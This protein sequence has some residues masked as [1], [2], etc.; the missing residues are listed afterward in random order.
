MVQQ[1]Y[2][3]NGSGAIAFY[4]ITF[5]RDAFCRSETYANHPGLI[6]TAVLS[7]IHSMHVHIATH[8]HVAS[9]AM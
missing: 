1:W 7:R 4:S 5:N 6:L 2:G 3:V 9:V 8:A